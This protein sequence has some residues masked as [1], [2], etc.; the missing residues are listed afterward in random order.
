MGSVLAYAAT[1]RQPFATDDSGVHALMMR[2]TSA[3]PDLTGMSGPLRELVESCL[4]K[5]PAERP[6][7]Q[8]IVE[9][10]EAAG[11]TARPWLP[12]GVAD[13]LARHAVSPLGL[14]APESGPETTAVPP[15]AADATTLARTKRM[16]S[17][18]APSPVPG[19][20]ADATSVGPPSAP[21]PA[22]TGPEP[23]PPVAPAARPGRSRTPVVVAAALILIAGVSYAVSLGDDE[24]PAAEPGGPQAATETTGAPRGLTSQGPSPTGGSAP[25][26]TASSSPASTSGSPPASPPPRRTVPP[27]FVGTWSGSSDDWERVRLVIRRGR[28]G[29]DVVTERFEGGR[30][31]CHLVG[32]LAAADDRSIRVDARV[33]RETFLS[34]NFDT[35]GQT[36]TLTGDDTLQWRP[37]NGTDSATLRKTG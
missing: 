6:S 19:R 13:K 24:T 32:R 22:P 15:S 34:C 30:L 4:A 25:S 12:P 8:Q 21:G 3:E 9:R 14:Q 27:A 7:P 5:E 35:G 36:M 17:S 16:T 28:I 1:G 29:R 20:A 33:S 26:A 10:A 18:A 2:I 11:P 23:A 37:D 31:T